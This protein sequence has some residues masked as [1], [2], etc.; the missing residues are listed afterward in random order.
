MKHL[1]HYVRTTNNQRYKDGTYIRTVASIC[2]HDPNPNADIVQQSGSENMICVA[3]QPIFH[4]NKIFV[5][6]VF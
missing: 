5:P 6:S 2:Q 3:T 1:I 4:N